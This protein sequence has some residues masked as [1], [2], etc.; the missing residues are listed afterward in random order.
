MPSIYAL[1]DCNNFYAS[2][3]KVF[4]PALKHKPV[5][6]LSNNDGCIIARS[7]EAK[8]LG[9]P[10]GAPYF[11][12]KEQLASN[13]VVVL[14]SN[15]ALYG[16]MSAR[17]MSVLE[18]FSPQVERYSID[19]AFIG[20][21]HVPLAELFHYASQIR[22][23]VERWTGIPVSIGI[24]TTKTLAKIANHVAKKDTSYHG[25]CNFLSWSP[26]VLE[27]F[28]CQLPVKE[29]WGIGWGSA[30]KLQAQDIL[31]AY[32]LSKVPLSQARKLLSVLGERIVLELQGIS[33]IPLELMWKP[34]KGIMYTRGF[35]RDIISLTEMEEAIATYTLRAWQKLSK[36]KSQASGLA[37][38]MKTNRFREKVTYQSH[39]Q[40]ALFSA[41]NNP[42]TLIKQALALVRKA[43]VPYTPYH[44][45]GVF[46]L[47]IE[48]G[49]AAPATLWEGSTAIFTE[50][51]RLTEALIELNKR[52]GKE[53]VYFAVQGK[54]HL[55]DMRQAFKS[56]NYTTAIT[57]LPL[58]S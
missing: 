6:I 33:C 49:A 42:N 38:F 35:G 54:N 37:L 5:V 46:L 25:C 39:T 18:Q 50:S 47:G 13:N 32:D 20:L 58:F 53:K 1:V 2:C 55:W 34:R 40:M 14:S 30:K 45:A 12:V 19:E 52:F 28:L 11:K 44:K 24:A 3:E 17:V 10:M 41:T 4:N 22:S 51:A 16:D 57:D 23:T 48:T 56:P 8:V 29:V 43:F 21:E 36:Q 7:A 9:I 27:D 26:L 15:Y 31:T